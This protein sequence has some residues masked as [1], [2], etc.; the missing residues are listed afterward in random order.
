MSTRISV[1]FCAALPLTIYVKMKQ[2][3]GTSSMSWVAIVISGI[4]LVVSLWQARI[5]HK[6]LWLDLYDRQF[7]ILS[8][9]IDFYN[10]LISDKSSSS[11][12]GYVKHSAFK[13]S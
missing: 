8:R 3:L 2:S 4:A 11:E 12:E 13:K 5:A 9:V 7:S 1:T 6:K 10:V